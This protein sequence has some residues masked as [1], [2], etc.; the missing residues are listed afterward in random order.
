[1][2]TGTFVLGTGWE[3]VECMQTSIDMKSLY[4]PQLMSTKLTNFK[5][6]PN[7]VIVACVFLDCIT[8]CSCRPYNRCDGNSVL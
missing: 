4:L 1:M 6:T 5:D 7:K 2:R 8:S 3:Q